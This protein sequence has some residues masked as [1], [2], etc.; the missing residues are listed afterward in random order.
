M[1]LLTLSVPRRWEA[2]NNEK[3][4]AC[5]NTYPSRVTIIDWHTAVK[6]HPGWVAG[7]RVHLRPEGMTGYAR[8]IARSIANPE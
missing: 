5:G 7:D 4:W 2:G 1:F 6:R 3:I 8:L